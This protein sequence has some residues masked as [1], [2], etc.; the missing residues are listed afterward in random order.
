VVFVLNDV[1]SFVPFVPLFARSGSFACT[2]GRLFTRLFLR[3]RVLRVFVGSVGVR[4]DAAVASPNGG[5]PS[6]KKGRFC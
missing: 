5:G 1:R 3:V 6:A 2:H 4:E